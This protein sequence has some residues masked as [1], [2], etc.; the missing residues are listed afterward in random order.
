MPIMCSFLFD[1]QFP[2]CNT[3]IIHSFLKRWHSL[4]CFRNFTTALDLIN[5]KDELWCKDECW[6]ANSENN[7][8]KLSIM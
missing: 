5:Q 2:Y 8:V 3:A 1:R 4:T 6:F 7:E